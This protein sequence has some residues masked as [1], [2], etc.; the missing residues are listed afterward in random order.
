MWNFQVIVKSDTYVG[1]DVVQDVR[2]V[3]QPPEAAPLEEEEDDISELGEDT[4]TGQLEAL[5][6]G[7]L[8]AGAGGEAAGGEGGEERVR[9]EYEDSTDESDAE[10]DGHSHD[11]HHGHDHGPGDDFVE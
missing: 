3:V 2:L 5:R 11:D 6:R 1:C 10:D 8:G 7:D 9:G 4:L